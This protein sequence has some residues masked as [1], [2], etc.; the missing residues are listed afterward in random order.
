M[1]VNKNQQNSVLKSNIL[2]L[3]TLHNKL[4]MGT[5]FTED[6]ISLARLFDKVGRSSSSSTSIT[7]ARG[8]HD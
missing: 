5:R 7:N 1:G 6:N 3:F 4:A 8:I 2:T